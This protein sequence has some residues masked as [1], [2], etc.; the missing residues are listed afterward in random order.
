MVQD[1]PLA[2][3]L[4]ASCELGQEVP[5]AAVHRR[6][7]R[8]GLRHAPGRAGRAG[9]LPPARLRAAG[10]RRTCPRPDDA[11][12]WR[13]PRNRLA[14]SG[15]RAAGT[16]R[17]T[18]AADER[19]REPAVSVLASPG[20]AREG[21]RQDRRPHR[22][23]R[24]RPHAG[25]AAA[26]RAAW[27]CCSG[28]TSPSSLLILLVAM[29]IKKPLDFAVFP[30][31]LLI[32]TLF[33]LALNVSSTRLVLTDGYA[34]KVI[35]AF[36]HFVIGGSLV[37]GLVIFVILTDR[38]VRRHHQRCRP[39]GRGRRP[40]HPRRHARQADGDRRRPQ[41][42]PDQRGAGPQAPPR[43]HRRGRL[44]RL[45]G[46][47]LEVRQGRRD[48]RHHRHAGQPRSAASPSA[49]CSAAWRPARRSRPTRC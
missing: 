16:G 18:A 13:P 38:P 9:R 25:R 20:W 35:E 4:H 26:G 46:R 33:R 36:G 28:S 3:A 17:R 7:P 42:R 48:R 23:R 37:V 19:G 44:L 1:I 47:C 15:D 43:G 12:R 29:Q 45:D 34:G 2:R 10:H 11:A 27:T 49:S 40:L 5:A 24:D 8:A 6:R 32:A 22:R 21:H 30:S 14:A 39:R 31:L 41:R